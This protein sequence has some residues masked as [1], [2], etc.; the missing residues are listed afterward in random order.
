MSGGH[1][2]NKFDECLGD[3]IY[4]K[5]HQFD[6]TGLRLFHFSVQV[7]KTTRPWFGS[8]SVS[9]PKY[10]MINGRNEG[11]LLK[12]FTPSWLCLFCGH[13]FLDHVS[14]WLLQCLICLVTS[15]VIGLHGYRFIEGSHV[16]W[17]TTFFFSP[18]PT[19]SF[20][21][22]LHSPIYCCSFYL[23]NKATICCD[24]YF[25]WADWF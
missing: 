2:W 13:A 17:Y 21:C 1:L 9:V 5:T 23:T 19:F 4:L 14:L 16:V 20:R 11:N 25:Y 22:S 18:S 6:P 7:R 8:G 12:T 24:W 15:L 10:K 3:R